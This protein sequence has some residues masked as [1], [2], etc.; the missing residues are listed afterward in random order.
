MSKKSTGGHAFP[1]SRGEPG[2][3]GMTYRQWLIGQVASNASLCNHRE[4]YKDSMA[5]INTADA[6]I[7]ALTREINSEQPE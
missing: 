3:S 7:A 1:L 2:M 6:I 4:L 5:A